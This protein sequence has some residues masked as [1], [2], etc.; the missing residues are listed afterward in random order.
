[1]TIEPTNQALQDY[2]EVVKELRSRG[3]PT[4]PTTIGREKAINPFLRWDVGTVQQAVRLTEP[5]AV[6]AE[7]RR[8][9][10]AL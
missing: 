3:L 1:L 5:A 9:K 10:E 6:F 2:A 8:R 7:L 4:V